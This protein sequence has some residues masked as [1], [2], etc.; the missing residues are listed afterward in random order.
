MIRKRDTDRFGYYNG[1]FLWTSEPARTAALWRAATFTSRFYEQAALEDVWVAYSDER[2]EFGKEHNFGWWRMLQSDIGADEEL[3]QWSISRGGILINKIPLA[4][5]HTHWYE[6]SDQATIFF[7]Q[8]VLRYL[9]K[10]P[11][12]GRFVK[13]IEREHL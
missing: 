5:I 3:A 1:G 11:S 13:F 6:K 4:S 12:A 2:F 9:K 7:N 8:T 10:I